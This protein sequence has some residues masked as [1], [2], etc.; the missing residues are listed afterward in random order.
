MIKFIKFFNYI[1]ILMIST[2]LGFYY[3]EL[4][5]EAFVLATVLIIIAIVASFVCSQYEE[6]SGE[7]DNKLEEIDRK[8]NEISDLKL[9]ISD[10]LININYNSP[11]IIQEY[12]DESINYEILKGR[13][14]TIDILLA[15]LKSDHTIKYLNVSFNKD[16][17]ISQSDLNK[18]SSY[19]LL[20]N[21]QAVNRNGKFEYNF[22]VKDNSRIDSVGKCQF[23]INSN[24][25]GKLQM[26]IEIM[27][28]IPAID[29]KKLVELKVV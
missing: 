2:F 29:K 28:D 12:I 1:V 25:I 9:R 13:K 6:I 3:T 14:Y 4:E 18:R 5:S 24:E 27:G 16:V 22:L 17:T 20:S 19:Y 8:N 23:D 10:L 21:I 15:T 11:Y 26:I 7:Y